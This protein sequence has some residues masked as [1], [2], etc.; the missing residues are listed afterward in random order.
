MAMKDAQQA[1]HDARQRRYDT[2]VNVPD[3]SRIKGEILK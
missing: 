1:L 3:Y 2:E